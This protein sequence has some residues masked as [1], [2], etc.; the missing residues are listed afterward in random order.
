MLTSG[1]MDN[2]VN[3]ANTMRLADALIKADKRFEMLIFPGMRHPYTPINDYVVM[4][5]MDFFAHWLLGSAEDGADIIELQRER[6][7]TPSTGHNLGEGR[8]GGGRGRG[9]NQ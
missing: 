9:E 5:R 1:D 3:I 6:Q 2:N 4:R 8:G 7:A